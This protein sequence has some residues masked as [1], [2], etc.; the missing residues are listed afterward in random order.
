MHGSNTSISTASSGSSGLSSSHGHKRRYSSRSNSFSS[1]SV[2]TVTKAGSLSSANTGTKG[3][4]PPMGSQSPSDTSLLAL[5]F[6]G[7]HVATDHS[8]RRSVAVDS[9]LDYGNIEG[10]GNL[11]RW[12][13]STDS[14]VASHTRRKR[15]SSGAILP[16]LTHQQPST[17]EPGYGGVDRPSP[18]RK[19]LSPLELTQRARFSPSGSPE[20]ERLRRRYRP[21]A[22]EGSLTALPPLHTTPSLVGLNEGDSPSTGQTETPSTTGLVTPSHHSTYAS[23]YFVANELSPRNRQKGKRSE[24]QQHQAASTSAEATHSRLPGSDESHESH[25]RSLHSV[26]SDNAS[27]YEMEGDSSQHR[28][29]RPR[30]R[31]EKDKKAML[32]KALQKANTA[33]L[34]DNAQNF[35]GALDAY[36]DAC[37]LLQMVMDRSSGADDKRKLDAIRVTYSNRIEELRQLEEPHPFT[38]NA[39]DEKDLPARP[40]SDD[41]MD[42][43]PD[44]AFVRPA[45]GDFGVVE[46]AS[47]ARI[48]RRAALEAPRILQHNNGSRDSFFAKT[49]KAVDDSSRQDFEVSKGHYDEEAE[50]PTREHAANKSKPK[51]QQSALLPPPADVT[52]MPAPLSPRRPPPRQPDFPHGSQQDVATKYDPERDTHEVGHRD[53]SPAPSQDNSNASGSWLDTIAESGSSCS[54]DSMHHV[55]DGLRTQRRQIWRAS[56]DSNPDFDTAFDAAVEAAYDDGFEPDLEVHKRRQ[57]AILH[58]RQESST[59]GDL[60]AH[61]RELSSVSNDFRPGF[62]IDSDLEEEEEERLLDEIASDFAQG[63]NFDLGMKS[64]LPRQS[65]SSAYT[66][67]TRSTWQS[68]QVSDRNTAGTSLSTAA[69]GAS[70]MRLSAQKPGGMTPVPTI[71]HHLPPMVPSTLR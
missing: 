29:T 47:E 67:S 70:A 11:N 9:T 68:S 27:R 60:S 26:Q 10:L 46:A 7:N 15:A 50:V 69:E 40:M 28:R 58:E 6:G 16:S 12:S 52:Y 66:R 51:L 48:V 44:T 20:R 5:R 13:Q 1:A 33:V 62:K 39:V 3:A 38:S 8:R 2:V 59:T 24:M 32:S 41:S 37:R 45:R 14:S 55:D 65:D 71:S 35:E 25:R 42:L 34:L 36:S 43:S 19:R 4:E 54:E 17:R 49:M 31:G 22:R 23:E 21:D 56:A 64:A 53:G 18:Q 61:V 63:F 57:T 30:E